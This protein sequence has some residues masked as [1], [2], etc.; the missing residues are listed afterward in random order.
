[1]FLTSL[2]TAPPRDGK[3]RTSTID[4]YGVPILALKSRNGGTVIVYPLFLGHGIRILSG[5]DAAMDLQTSFVTI[6]S[7]ESIE[8]TAEC[9]LMVSCFAIGCMILAYNLEEMHC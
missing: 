6:G 1:M 9:R 7:V 4:Q 3:E 2:A 5:R 8:I